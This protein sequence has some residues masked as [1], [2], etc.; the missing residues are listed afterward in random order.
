MLVEFQEK[1][2]LALSKATP[3]KSI[4]YGSDTASLRAVTLHPSGN[5]AGIY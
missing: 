1:W 4:S 2:G 3:W 5:K